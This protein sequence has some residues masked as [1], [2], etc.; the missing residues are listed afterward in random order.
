MIL[1]DSPMGKTVVSADFPLAFFVLLETNN[2][3]RAKEYL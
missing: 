3:G 1:T 2:L